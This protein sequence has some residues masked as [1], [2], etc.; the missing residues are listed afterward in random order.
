MTLTNQTPWDAAPCHRLQLDH[1][2]RLLLSSRKLEWIQ[3]NTVRDVAVRDRDCGEV[4]VT[5]RRDFE[6]SWPRE[7]A[8]Y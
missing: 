3:R 6:Q 4:F 8:C 5:D 7:R 1:F 2:A